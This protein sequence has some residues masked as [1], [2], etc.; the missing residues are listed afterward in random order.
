MPTIAV[1]FCSLVQPGLV[2]KAMRHTWSSRKRHRIER[3]QSDLVN[4]VCQLPTVLFKLRGLWE[5]TRYAFEYFTTREVVLRSP[6]YVEQLE[7]A[8]LLP[9]RLGESHSNCQLTVAQTT[10]RSL[11]LRLNS[12][13]V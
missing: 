6:V 7:S 10:A 13:L 9:S 1:P 11:K 4:S 8:N 3:R 12:F 2:F 5:L